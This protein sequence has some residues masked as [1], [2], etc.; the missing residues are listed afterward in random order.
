MDNENIVDNCLN[1][2]ESEL[3]MEIELQRHSIDKIIGSESQSADAS[4]SIFKLSV[5]CFRE[6]FDYLPLEDLI[7][8]GQTCKRMQRIAGDFFHSNY[9][10][11]SA[12]GQNDGIYILSL[13]ANIFGQYIQ[14]I[15]ISG[16]Q[17][18]AYRFVGE[19][20]SNSIKHFRAYG[21][22]PV[23]GFKYIEGILKGVEVLEMNECLI[24]GEF[25][26]DHL[27]YCPNLK[28]LNITRSGRIRDNSIIIGNGNE[29][30]LRKYPSIKHF[31]LVE[32]YGLKRNELKVFFDQN[33][34]IRTF[35]TDSKGLW[36]N[37]DSILGSD[38][39]LDTLA[40]DMYQ[41]KLFDSN[42]Q[43]ISMVDSVYDLL[44]ALHAR[45]FH[46]YLHLYLLFVNQL[47]ISK[48]C[49]LGDI[50]MLN[51]D[52]IRID[53]LLPE[54]KVF[55]VWS[56]DEIL[57][58]ENIPVN[59]PN[60]E[61]ISMWKVTSSTILPFIRSL[62]RLR[63]IR[64]GSLKDLNEFKHFDLSVWSEERKR[65]S[66]AS[67]VAIYVKEDAYLAAKW[68]MKSIDFEFVELKRFESSEWEELCSRTKYLK[69]F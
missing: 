59:I 13:Q 45:D 27:K 39:K 32:F 51:G 23:G 25:Y 58:I 7:A 16:D 24:G 42:D 52:I 66:A 9:A 8:I 55:A 41:S 2:F 33:R 3:G 31:E 26:E 1:G 6:V 29:W 28:S 34:N 12:R 18:G 64:I 43:P 49:T 50:E 22:L 62:P 30:L 37:K 53:R 11:K 47:H 46:K 65:L 20:C 44:A 38:I 48:L 60:I 69:S 4:P 54:V 19:N 68:T 40:V 61:R 17:L 14:K 63:Q 67:K 57:N 15:S 56:G 36:E 21:S 10:A 35:C 5:D